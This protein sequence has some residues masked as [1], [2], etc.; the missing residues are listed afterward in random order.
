MWDVTTGEQ[1]QRFGGHVHTVTAIAITPDQRLVISGGGNC[2]RRYG[3]DFTIKLWDA[4]TGELRISL[5]AHRGPVVAVLVTP[6][7]QWAV[8][9]GGACPY[10]PETYD[11]S[12]RVWDLAAETLAAT[13]QG[14]DAVTCMVLPDPQTIVAGSRDGAVHIL[15]FDR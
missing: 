11:G 5:D 13:F 14:D 9:G 3:P 10:S 7:S 1:V 12:I 2:F 8:S 6:D 4:R 15:R